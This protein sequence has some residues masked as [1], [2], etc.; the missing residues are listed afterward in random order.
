MDI[1]VK[2]FTPTGS[3]RVLSSKSYSHRYLISAFIANK[4]VTIQEVNLCEDVMATIE[5]L[6]TMG[7]VFKIEKNTVKY[8]KRD[9][10]T[11]PITLNVGESGTTLRM[12]FP[13][14]LYLFN[15]VKFVGKT[16]LF[17]RPMGV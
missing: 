4:P 7:A 14:A 1:E 8:I 17:A 2:K 9:A 13:I 6:E 5:C 11:S 12:L 16:S 10:K 3:I 15:D